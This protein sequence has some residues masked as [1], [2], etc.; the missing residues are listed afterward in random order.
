[1]RGLAISL[2]LVGGA[3]ATAVPLEQTLFSMDLED[4]FIPDP[5]EESSLEILKNARANELTTYTF[6]QESGLLGMVWVEEFSGPQPLLEWGVGAWIPKLHRG[7]EDVLGATK[8][9]RTQLTL[10][11][12][13]SRPAYRE[14]LTIDVD[15][16]TLSAECLLIG[17]RGERIAVFLIA[18]PEDTVQMSEVGALFSTSRYD[19]APWA[20]TKPL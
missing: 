18:Q 9:T 6:S 16:L 20:A 11:R 8:I 14:Q 13:G 10:G 5:L 1:M 4:D 3:C 2:A 15:D 7:L 12:M 19:D 17:G